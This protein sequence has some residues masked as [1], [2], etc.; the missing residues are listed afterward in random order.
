ML[1]HTKQYYVFMALVIVAAAVG[2]VA[3]AQAQC[4]PSELMCFSAP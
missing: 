3:G 2:V 1:H 4:T